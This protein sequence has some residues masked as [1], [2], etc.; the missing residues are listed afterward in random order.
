MK[1]ISLLLG[2]ALLSLT[3]CELIDKISPNGKLGGTQSPMG[4]VGNTF[5]LGTIAGVGSFTG[6]VTELNDGIS[7]INASITITDPQLLE[8]AKSARGFSWNG[9][10]GTVSKKYRITDEGIQSVYDE[11]DFTL[12]KY[13]G[14]VGDSYS[15]KVG[16]NKLTR[17]IDYKSTEDEYSYAFWDIKV[18]KVTETG[19]PLPGVNKLEFVTNH[20]FGIVGFKIYFEDGS[21]K[22]VKF[23]SKSDV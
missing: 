3:S 20:K 15:I 6:E 7:T 10:T 14:K 13:D 9:N 22:E 5:S 21:E 19:R 4:E 23:F 12:V 11:G 1:K 16:G 2:L 17:T 8:L 18:I